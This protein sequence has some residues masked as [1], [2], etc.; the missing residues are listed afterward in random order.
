MRP[1]IASF[2]RLACCCANPL[3]AVSHSTTIQ[4]EIDWNGEYEQ[5]DYS[6]AQPASKTKMN[7]LRNRRLI[8]LPSEPFA[9]KLKA[10]AETSEVVDAFA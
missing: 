2:D 7:K 10:T 9:F 8:K 6:L 5:V 4:K 1:R 3:L